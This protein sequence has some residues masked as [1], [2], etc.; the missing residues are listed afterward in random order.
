MLIAFLIKDEDDWR[1][2]R[3]SVGK[4]SGKSVVH[5]AETEPPLHCHGMER[6]SAVD[7]VETFDDEEDEGGDPDEGDGE[8]VE[9]P[10][11]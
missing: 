5:V 3:Q 1:C 2:W 9:R 4:A 7:E 10:Q 8:I 11:T 6:S